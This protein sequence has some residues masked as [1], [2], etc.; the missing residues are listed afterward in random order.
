MKQKKEK[1]LFD[2][3]TEVGRLKLEIA[4]ELGL[5]DKIE[6]RGWK[7]LTSK[8]SGAIGGKI[9]GKRRTKNKTDNSVEN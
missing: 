1:P 7:N 3:D 2:L 5:K 6:A 9:S 4:E 8:E